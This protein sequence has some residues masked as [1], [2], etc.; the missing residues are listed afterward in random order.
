[1]HMKNKIK[2]ERF[3]IV[4]PTWLLDSIKNDSEK[5]GVSTSDYIRDILKVHQKQ[6]AD[7]DKIGPR[8]Q[9]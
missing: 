3:H 8:V 5:L 1:M 2:T 4:M 7:T 9:C 6:L